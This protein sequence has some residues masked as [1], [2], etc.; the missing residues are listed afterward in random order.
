MEFYEQKE[1]QM[2]GYNE[3]SGPGLQGY[4]SSFDNWA[5]TSLRGNMVRNAL[6]SVWTSI[7]FAFII[8]VITSR[9]IWISLFAILCISQIIFGLLSSIHLLDWR[10]GMIESTCLIVFIGVSVDYVVHICHHYVASINQDR[11]GRMNHAFKNT[12]KTIVGGALTSCFSGIFLFLCEAD[13]LNKF[14][15]MLLI[16]IGASMLTSL[17]FLPS[18]LFLVGPEKD[19]GTIGKKKQ[20][21]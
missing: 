5:W 12:G 20:I 7:A 14:G 18:I 13:A 11:V 9:N 21:D 16:T 19:Q 17:V 6:T 4:Q 1:V 2:K 8:L 3:I 15:V 10:L